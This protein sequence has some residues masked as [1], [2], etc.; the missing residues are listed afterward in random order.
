MVDIVKFY[1]NFHWGYRLLTYIC[2]LVSYR[3]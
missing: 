2:V 1:V 3:H